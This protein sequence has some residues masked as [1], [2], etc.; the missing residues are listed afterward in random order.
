[1]PLPNWKAQGGGSGGR[2]WDFFAAAE[3]IKITASQYEMNAGIVRWRFGTNPKFLIE[4]ELSL[5]AGRDEP[6]ISYHFTPQEAGWYS[7]GYAGAPEIN[8]AALA[9]I[10]QPLV[11]Q[12]KR[13][14]RLSFLSIEDVCPI[15]A[16]FVSSENTTIGV[17]ADPV[18]SP[19]RL[20]TEE[21]SRFG[22]LVRNGAGNAQPMVFAPVLG[23]RD[24]QMKAGEI[25]HFK[26]RLMV[27]PGSVFEAYKHL[28]RNL[29][30]FHDY[31]ENAAGSLNETLENMIAYA[32]NDFYSG[33]VADLRGFDYTT[34]VEK[35]VKVVSSLHPLSLAMITDDEEIYRRRALPVM[36]YLMSRQKYLF[37]LVEGELDQNPSHAMKGPAA[38]ISELAALHLM[39]QDRSD[40]F[41]FY[42]TSL[43]DKP[44]ALNLEV[45]S[46][47]ASWQSLLAM[48]R[49]TG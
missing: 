35:T 10:W 28:A 31:R 13:F 11:W 39:S 30:D 9:E 46:E 4:A 26:L 49:M 27:Q 2:T 14:P 48:Y 12:E 34:D 29:Y 40:I 22:V 8:P 33:W 21:N 3:S 24:S 6:L 19:F 43:L 36:E 7:I 38:E 37:S 32:M 25:Y 47:G 18:E 20:P 16:T 23:G 45:V 5:P 1:M 44:R 17:A 41:K 15:T 42:A